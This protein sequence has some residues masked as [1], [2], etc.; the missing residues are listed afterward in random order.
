LE[1][2]RFAL[3][4]STQCFSPVYL[5]RS[6]REELHQATA[7][8]KR[9][10]NKG[11]AVPSGAMRNLAGLIPAGSHEHLQLQ[12]TEQLPKTVVARAVSIWATEVERPTGM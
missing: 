2:E 1:V 8:E 7:G 5:S 10:L 11:E 6:Y 3:L 12:S 9:A 4:L